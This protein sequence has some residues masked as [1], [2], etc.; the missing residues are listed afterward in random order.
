M[1]ARR[2]GAKR[3]IRPGALGPAL[4][5]LQIQLGTMREREQ[6]LLI[7][8]LSIGDVAI[9]TDDAARTTFLNPSA[10]E[11]TGCALGRALGRPF[12]EVFSIYYNSLTG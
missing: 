5:A 3:R 2:G 9:A 1:P 6:S 12:W 11:L 10:Q 7:T 4:A 8:L